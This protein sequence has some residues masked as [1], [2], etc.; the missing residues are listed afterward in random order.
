MHSAKYRT[1]L[2]GMPIDDAEVEDFRTRMQMLGHDMTPAEAKGRYL[3]L[4]NLFWILVH[5]PSADG[6]PPYE[7]PSPPWL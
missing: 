5:V 2:T 7:P 6:E 1:T 3:K 4:L